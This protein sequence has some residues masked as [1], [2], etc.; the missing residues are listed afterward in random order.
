ME[1]DARIG[2]LP[3][4]E[5]AIWEL[6]QLINERGPYVDVR[7]IDA[8]STSAARP[9]SSST[10]QIA[11]LTGGAVTAPAQTQRI[12]KWLAEH[13]CKI[14]EP[15]EIHGRRRTAGAGARSQARQLLELRQSSRRGRR[16][17][18][19]HPEALGQH[20][21]RAAHPLCVS[22]PRRIGRTFH[23]AWAPAA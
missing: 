18:V 23:V 10:T 19:R 12:L 1:I 15:A 17:E 20:R 22:L 13:G 6:D 16:L 21:G 11:E 5:Q 9:S 14:V 2:L 4:S 8:A 3:P 7:L